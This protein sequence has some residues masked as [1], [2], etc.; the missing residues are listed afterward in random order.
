LKNVPVLLI[1]GVGRSGTNVLKDILNLHSEVCSFP[2]EARFTIDPD[3]IIPTYVLLKESWSP[4][5]SEKAI[6]RLT[7]FLNRLSRKNLPDIMAIGF[8]SLF[9]QLGL[10]G[11]IRSYKEWELKKSFPNFE[12]HNNKLINDLKLL[13]YEGT[14]VGRK[15]SLTK[16]ALN[17]VGLSNKNN[18]LTNI[19]NEYF[20]NLYQDLLIA[21]KKSLYVEDNTFNILYADYYEQLLPN[22]FMV[23]MIRDPRDVVSSYLNQRWCPKDIKKAI[24]YYIEL[25]E[26][27]LEI[28]KKLNKN[29]YI[30]IK[31]EELCKNT[32]SVL[33]N[34]IGKLD[35]EFEK[36]ITSYDL[37]KSN[38]GR[39]NKEF[40]EINKKFLNRE[41]FKY[42]KYFGYDNS[43]L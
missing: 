11:N 36:K 34:L 17:Y 41:L 43:N 37:S 35:I 9:K 38:I 25:M 33:K 19:F 26:R 14:W 16:K 13:E 40:D 1:G 6:A 10:D 22:A 12:T 3:G 21:K 4:F 7:I 15:G 27:W 42:I 20:C 32:N 5:V 39:W 29:F 8:S 31:L 23:H 28:K 18:K 24:K 30:E 2:F